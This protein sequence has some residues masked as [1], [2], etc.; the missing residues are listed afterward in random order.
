M[1]EICRGHLRSVGRSSDHGGHSCYATGQLTSLVVG[2]K[3]IDIGR[4]VIMIIFDA[5]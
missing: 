1:I 5:I 3:V 2:G 4:F